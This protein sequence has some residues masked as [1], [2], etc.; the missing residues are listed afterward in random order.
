MNKTSTQIVKKIFLASGSPPDKD[1]LRKDGNLRQKSSNV[2]HHLEG[3]MKCKFYDNMH[4][5]GHE[6]FG[7][8]A[9]T[10]N[11]NGGQ[12]KVSIFDLTCKVS[13][14]SMSIFLMSPA[15]I[16]YITCF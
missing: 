9:V 12:Q 11:I 6:N 8:F 14:S 3:T 13:K 10:F 15:V 7:T 16:V 2:N 5:L 4:C 1:L